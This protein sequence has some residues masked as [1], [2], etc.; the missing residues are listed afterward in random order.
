[1]SMPGTGPGLAGLAGPPGH[2]GG[3]GGMGPGGLPPGRAPGGAIPGRTLS[4]GG[5][6]IPFLGLGRGGDFSIGH[7][8]M[9]ILQSGSMTFSQTEGKMIS[10]LGPIKS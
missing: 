3:M 10:P 7:M 6:G 5:I 9:V 4:G 1:M 8:V 2:V